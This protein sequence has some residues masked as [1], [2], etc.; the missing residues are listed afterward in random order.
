MIRG[1]EDLAAHT[2]IHGEINI[3][4]WRDWSRRNR[5]ARL[6]LDRGPRFDRS[7][8]AIRAAA[9]GLGVCLDSMLLAEQ[10]LRSGQL[11]VVVPET[12][13]SARGHGFTTPRSKSDAPKVANF[14]EWLFDEVAET[15]AWWEDSLSQAA[16]PPDRAAERGGSPDACHQMLVTRCLRVAQ[17]RAVPWSESM[18]S[19]SFGSATWGRLRRP[20]ASL[21]EGRSF[22]PV[23][24][25]APSTDVAE[26]ATALEPRSLSLPAACWDGNAR[27]VSRHWL[28]R[29]RPECV[30]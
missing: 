14:R 19:N 11:V 27:A 4:G 29:P 10:E 9:D 5:K 16:D 28:R 3:L 2:L 8:M 15:K 23:A 30:H 12:A 6:D 24:A 7:F 25:G 22:I 13:M 17:A 18:Q 21:E 1:V 26:L 20:M